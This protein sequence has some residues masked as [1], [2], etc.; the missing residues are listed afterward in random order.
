[1]KKVLF[2]WSNNEFKS[3]VCNYDMLL[4]LI[5]V[6]TMKRK[7]LY[8]CNILIYAI[9]HWILCIL[10]HYDYL[11]WYIFKIRIG[12]ISNSVLIPDNY[13]NNCRSDCFWVINN[14]LNL[15]PQNCEGLNKWTLVTLG[16]TNIRKMFWTKN[17][18]LT[19]LL[20][21]TLISL[22]CT[23][24]SINKTLSTIYI[25]KMSS[26]IMMFIN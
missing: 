8:S 11:R 26:L 6:Y 22:Y 14:E 19:K 13:F 12:T 9:N 17:N 1:M 15:T 2:Y 18:S 25:Q 4:W 20:Y 23:H 7:Q 24:V 16:M 21:K 5:I 3:Y 10:W